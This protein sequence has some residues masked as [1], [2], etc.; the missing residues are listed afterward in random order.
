MKRSG[1]FVARWGGEEFITLLPNTDMEGAVN[2][3]EQIRSGVEEMDVPCAGGSAAK[4]TVSIGVNSHA[5]GADGTVDALISGADNALY[6]A[7]ETGRNRICA[8][9][10]NPPYRQ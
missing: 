5:C 8:A 9:D 10:E 7:K 3:A 2:V 1:D 6:K 4:I